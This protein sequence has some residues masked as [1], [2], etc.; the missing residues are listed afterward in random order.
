MFQEV[1]REAMN[2]SVL[3]GGHRELHAQQVHVENLRQVILYIRLQRVTDKARDVLEHN[4][5]ER[6]LNKSGLLDEIVDRLQYDE[7]VE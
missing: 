7:T 1:T 6:V 5:S 3:Y 2:E 4:T